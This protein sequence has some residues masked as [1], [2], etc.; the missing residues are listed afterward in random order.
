MEI[1]ETALETA[2]KIGIRLL[3]CAI[4]GQ[5]RKARKLIADGQ[6]GQ[7]KVGQRRRRF[8]EREARVRAAFDDRHGASDA[9]RQQGGQATREAGSDDK[10]IDVKM[11]RNH[12]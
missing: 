9:V 4:F 12:G 5:G 2:H 10:H 3:P 7:D 6:F 1:A 8:T 11:E